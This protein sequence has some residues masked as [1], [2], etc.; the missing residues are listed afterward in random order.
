M[1][2]IQKSP[3]AILPQLIIPERIIH[4][5]AEEA[6]AHQPT[7]TGQALLGVRTQ[8]Q[9]IGWTVIPDLTD[10][11]REWGYFEQGGSDQVEV[12]KWLR[13][14]WDEMR[15]KSRKTNQLS[16]WTSQTQ[17]PAGM[18]PVELDLPLQHF[19]DWHKHPEFLKTL[20]GTDLGTI[21]NDMFSRE[22]RRTEWVAP[23][24]T[25]SSDGLKLV[26]S[27][28]D[29][30]GQE[31]S[32][33]FQM[34]I[35]QNWY[36]LRKNDPITHPIKPLIVE[37]QYV[38]WAPPLPWYLTDLGRLQYEV[39]ELRNLGC[40]VRWTPKQMDTDLEFEIIFGVDHPEWTTRLMII[41]QWN[42][43]YS[44]PAVRKYPKAQLQVAN[45]T[46]NTSEKIKID[47][48]GKIKN[49]QQ[50]LW[51]VMYGPGYNSTDFYAPKEQ[52]FQ[53][54]WKKERI[55]ADLVLEM[56]QRGELING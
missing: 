37:D 44:L 4:Y 39:Q 12:L 46:A 43:P 51:N 50:W 3:P 13:A 15:L 41:T 29:G 30:S 22:T 48:L 23:I 21:H 19:G 20:S 36:Y 31:I 47:P 28:N 32:G 55:L 52:L 6:M 18:V 1:K 53:K 17:I 5:I 35:Q 26:L 10:T 40:E 56:G 34:A 54:P 49:L 2:R 8:T 24:I 27:M 9:I 7:E 25:T 14:H 33:T 11:I 42:Y 45:Q 16:G 38:P